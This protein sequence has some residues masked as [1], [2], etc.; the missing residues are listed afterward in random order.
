MFQKI[1]ADGL[2]KMSAVEIGEELSYSFVDPRIE[3][4]VHFLERYFQDA[5]LSSYF[6]D[7]QGKD[8]NYFED[9]QLLHRIWYSYILSHLSRFFE[10]VNLRNEL[11]IIHEYKTQAS[12]VYRE[13]NSIN[14]NWFKNLLTYAETRWNDREARAIIEDHLTPDHVRGIYLRLNK[15]KLSLKE[16]LK[17]SSISTVQE[18]TQYMGYS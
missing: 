14:A 3:K 18:M 16:E 12:E 5:L 6:W 8:K 9:I 7:L 2:F 11:A 17:R 13:L 4:T 15:L 1:A 10:N